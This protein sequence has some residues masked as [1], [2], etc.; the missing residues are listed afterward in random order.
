MAFTFET[1]PAVV[2]HM[3]AMDGSAA[4]PNSLEAIRTSL[5]AGAAVIEVDIN[6]LADG[7]YLLVHDDL[8]EAETDGSGAVLAC[9]SQ[10]ARGLHIQHDR[11]ATALSVPL[12]SDVIHLFSSS[13]AS[14]RLQLD[15]KN[16]TPFQ[17]D[18]P[19]LRL[20]RLV[21]PLQERVIVSSGA[22]WQLRKLRKIAPWLR[23]GFDIMLYLGWEPQGAQRDPRDFPRQLGAYGYYDDHILASRR[24]MT[25][26]A[27]LHD[28]CASLVRQVEDVSVFYLNHGLIAQSLLDGFNWA[29]QLHQHGIWLD[30]WT[31]DVTRPAAVTNA[32]LLYQ[33]GVDLFT[34]NTPQALARLLAGS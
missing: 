22:D 11:V 10:D 26:F 5:A 32:P 27:Y 6:A 2:H 14:T 8:L 13:G 34:S 30:A 17:D 15:F 16:L 23:L 20:A 31:M 28:R 24:A 9:S 7:D 19:L 4:P 12:L 21:E 29:E 18:E 33:A 1:K 25:P 3:G